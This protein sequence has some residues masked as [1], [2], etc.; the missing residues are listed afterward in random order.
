MNEPWLDEWCQKAVKGQCRLMFDIGANTGEWS[1]WGQGHF[2]QVI[3]VDADKRAFGHLEKRFK[4]ID[5]VTPIY[6]AVDHSAGHAAV[7]RRESP[8]QTSLLQVHPI[9]GVGQEAAP[10]MNI[11]FVEAVSLDDLAV[12]YGAPDFVK[13]DVEGAEGDV[14]AGATASCF[15]RCRWLIEIHDR[16]R[17]VG[18]QLE[19]IGIDMVEIIKHPMPDA[20]PQHFWVYVEGDRA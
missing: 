13:V 5:N 14:L 20:H 4:K 8:D 19:R 1:E 17:E 9:G 2:A 6:A 12:K 7:Y 16:S 18:E 15:R 3:A 10:V 11:D